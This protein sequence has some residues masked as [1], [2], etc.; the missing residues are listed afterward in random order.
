MNFLETNFSTIIAT[1]IVGPIRIAHSSSK[2]YEDIMVPMATFET[3]LWYSTQRGAIVSQRSGGINTIVLQDIMTRSIILETPDTASAA[4]CREWILAHKDACSKV[5]NESSKHAKLENIHIEIVSNLIYLHFSLEVGN[6]S[7]HNMVTKAA[8]DLA[9]FIIQ[10]FRP[11]KR[12]REISNL[13]PQ[14]H[15]N[16]LQYISVSGNYCVDKKVSAINGILGR[17][18]RVCAE[19]IVPRNIC[20]SILKT[21]PEKICELNLKK[22]MLGSILAGSLRSANAHYA[23]AILAIFLATGQDAANIVEASQGITFAE[24]VEGNEGTTK[25]LY[26]S[27]NIPNLIV[28]TVGNGKNLDFAQNNLEIMGCD[29]K[30][31][32][33]SKRLA[34]IIASS[35]LC[36]ELSLMAALT[37]PEELMQAHISLE[38]NNE[39]NC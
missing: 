15:Q 20:E 1:K 17:G 27:I 35:V 31:P 12:I 10:N 19:I 2:I 29:A 22:N 7:G 13:D 4:E 33:S 3:P 36:S 37:N 32:D 34:S 38:R 24:I 30:N 21:T 26:F 28:G 11:Q 39:K 23:N 8:D 6:A 5:V 18:K 9:A 14:K 25:D 16:L